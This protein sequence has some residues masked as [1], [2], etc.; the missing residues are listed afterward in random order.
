MCKSRRLF[1]TGQPWCNL[2]L[3]WNTIHT[4]CFK[5]HRLW[6]FAMVALA[7]GYDF[8]QRKRTRKYIQHEIHTLPVSSPKKKLQTT[9]VI[10]CPFG[11]NQKTLMR[12]EAGMNLEAGTTGEFWEAALLRYQQNIWK[13]TDCYITQEAKKVWVNSIYR[14]LNGA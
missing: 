9:P 6:G 5:W 7:D 11:N 8:P 1:R 10:A 3:V 4:W 12:W 14:Y 2:T 13:E